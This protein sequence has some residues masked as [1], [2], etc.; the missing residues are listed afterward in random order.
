[1]DFPSLTLVQKELRRGVAKGYYG[2]KR[3]ASTVSLNGSPSKMGK[4]DALNRSPNT[5]RA[6]HVES[7]DLGPRI[8]KKKS[9]QSSSPSMSDDSEY[10]TKD[11]TKP[12]VKS[13][14]TKNAKTGVKSDEMTDVKKE[15][16]GEV[17]KE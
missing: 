10:D 8:P 16:K 1:M 2:V 11:E 9:T 13:A 7:R 17:K 5:M 12:V 6:S 3:S 15:V 14:T 4:L